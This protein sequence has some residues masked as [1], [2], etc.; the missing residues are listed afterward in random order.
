MIFHQKS[1]TIKV[2]KRNTYI[3]DSQGKRL[4]NAET[5]KIRNHCRRLKP[6]LIY[7]KSNYELSHTFFNNSMLF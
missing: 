3:K 1:Y 6:G 2:V 5:R 7:T 4:N